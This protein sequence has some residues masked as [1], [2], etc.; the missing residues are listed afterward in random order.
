MTTT[1]EYVCSKY[2]NWVVDNIYIE[3][4]LS[5]PQAGTGSVYNFGTGSETNLD[6]ITIVM[7]AAS[8]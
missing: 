2:A 5:I 4:I 3:I 7:H 1:H 6:V 8:S